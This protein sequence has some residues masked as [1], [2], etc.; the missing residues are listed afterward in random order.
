MVWAYR[1]RQ[2]VP[3]YVDKLCFSDEALAAT[4]FGI[5]LDQVNWLGNIIAVVYIAVTPFIPVVCT[6]Y[7]LKF[8]VRVPIPAPLLLGSQA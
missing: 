5:T 1:E 6:R 2:C 8:C 3:F 7:G 4:E